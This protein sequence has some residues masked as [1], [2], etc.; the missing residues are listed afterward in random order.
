MLGQFKDCPRKFHWRYVRHL[1]PL[2][3]KNFVT[4]FGSALHD[5][6]AEWYSTKDSKKMDKAFVDSWL[7]H[8]G[9]DETGKRSMLRGLTITRQ[10][11]ETFT[12]E[13]FDIISPEYVE[14]GFTMELGNHLICGKIDAIVEW[15]LLTRGIVTLEHKFSNSKGYLVCEPNAQLDTYIWAASKIMGKPVIGAYLNQ[16]YHT[17]KDV[18][19]NEFV[20][21]L[22]YRTEDK[23]NEWEKD[24]LFYIGLI[25]RC[26][27]E[28]IWPK[29]TKH[30]GAYHRA[31]EYTRL[32]KITDKVEREEIIPLLYRVEQWNPFPNAREGGEE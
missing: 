14:T 29:N 1:I 23:I 12:N 21:E 24:T 16:V 6:M 5:A 26:E 19:K 22:T 15:K 10:Y 7:P 31:C 20:R 3:E 2:Y 32:C 28:E 9:Q 27:R 30:C 11:R 25:D 18:N 13:P 8:E 17:A 4:G